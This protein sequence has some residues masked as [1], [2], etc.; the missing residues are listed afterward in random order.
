[1]VLSDY[2]KG[3]LTER[4]IRAIIDAA[5]R[6]GTPV[7]VDPKFHDYR[8]YRG[9]TLITP[10]RKEL[11][12]A[13]HRPLSTETEIAAAAAE[14][15]RLVG[16][17][18]VLV[19]RSEE[20]MTLHVEGHAPVHVPAYPVKVRNVSGVGDT[21]VAVMAVLLALRAPFEAAMR[22]A[23]QVRLPSS[24]ANAGRG[25]MSRS[26]S[27]P[28]H[29]ACGLARTRGQDNVRLVG[30]RRAP[31]RVAT[32]RAAHRFTNGCFDLLHRGHI[33]LLAEA[34]TAC[35]RGRPWQPLR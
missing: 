28:S 19:K 23:K 8:V 13:V 24:W 5:R 30:A 35:D 21:V 31:C 25:R 32:V 16:S 29:P 9:A 6:R 27:A 2:V 3:V 15:A 11:A 7:I 12:A 1:M 4:V 34:R 22:A 33:R 17:E 20:G 18:A 26:P 14:L 10:N